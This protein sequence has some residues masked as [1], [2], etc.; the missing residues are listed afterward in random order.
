MG[1]NSPPISHLFADD[2]LLCSQAKISQMQCVQD[3]MNLF[4]EMSSQEVSKEKTQIYFPK[5][6]SLHTKTSLVAV[7]GIFRGNDFGATFRG[8]SL[9]EDTQK[10]TRYRKYKGPL[11]R[12][13]RTTSKTHAVN[14]GTMCLP[15]PSG[16]EE[17][18]CHEQSLSHETGMGYQKQDPFV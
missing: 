1:R 18:Q 4:C 8:S 16:H 13:N 7:S 11:S 10:K 9:K 6:V 12:E 2:L 3:T 5:N 17:S 14:W 15:K